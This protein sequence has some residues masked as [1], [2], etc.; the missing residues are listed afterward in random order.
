MDVPQVRTVTWRTPG[1][2]EV[3]IDVRGLFRG[4]PK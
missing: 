4:V 2:R 3:E 1:G